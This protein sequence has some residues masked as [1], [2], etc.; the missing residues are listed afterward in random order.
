[1]GR[2]AQAWRHRPRL[3]GRLLVALITLFAAAA[4]PA[5]AYATA[6]G[7]L[8]TL[9]IYDEDSSDVVMRAVSGSAAMG[10][11][12]DGG[13]TTAPVD[14]LQYADDPLVVVRTARLARPR[15]PPAS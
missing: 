6:G 7:L 13:I 12:D 11:L 8:S 10:A 2:L 9:G 5:I 15:G 14:K 4:L 3:H 1:M